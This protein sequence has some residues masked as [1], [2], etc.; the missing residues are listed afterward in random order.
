M[1]AIRNS[2]TGFIVKPL[3]SFQKFEYKMPLTHRKISHKKLG[4]YNFAQLFLLK[5]ISQGLDIFKG[6]YKK[7]LP[8][9]RATALQR[10][11]LFDG[12]ARKYPSI[13]TI[14]RDF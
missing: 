11:F 5:L 4:G 1:R 10:Q 12:C 9:L 7:Y 2:C 8:T 6:I 14:F 3:G 13:S